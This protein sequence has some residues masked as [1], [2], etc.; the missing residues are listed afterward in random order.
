MTGS[1]VSRSGAELGGRP[2]ESSSPGLCP[3]TRHPLTRPRGV[4]RGQAPEEGRGGAGMQ[5]GLWVLG[6]PMQRQGRGPQGG[7]CWLPILAEQG[8]HRGLQGGP[9]APARWTPS[10][11]RRGAVRLVWAAGAE[12][13]GLFLRPACGWV[14]SA[15]SVVPSQWDQRTGTGILRGCPHVLCR[16]SRFARWLGAGPR[17]GAVGR[18]CR[19]K[20][21]VWVRVGSRQVSFV[22]DRGQG[23]GRWL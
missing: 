12:G 5:G 4:P 18:G 1:H 11:W 23:A 22:G 3:G 8:R 6:S 7:H 17:G 16:A 20:V 14:G 13:L 21:A 2:A 19:L 10:A 9:P 15:T